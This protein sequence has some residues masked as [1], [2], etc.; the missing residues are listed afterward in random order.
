MITTIAIQI[1]QG[2]KHRISDTKAEI[3]R[4]QLSETQRK[5]EESKKDILG[6]VRKKKDD[7]IITKH[8]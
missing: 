4:Q 6:P 8:D 5:Y 7:E 3:Y 1:Q 2:K